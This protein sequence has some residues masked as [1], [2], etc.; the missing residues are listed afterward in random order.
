MSGDDF[1]LARVRGLS[2]RKTFAL[3]SA[4]FISLTLNTPTF[5]HFA[6]AAGLDA[7]FY[8]F[9][10]PEGNKDMI[11]II[12]YDMYVLPLVVLYTCVYV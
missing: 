2:F 6:M 3:R 5:Q 7:A 9:L 10:S 12:Q 1:L 4:V 8:R 11:R